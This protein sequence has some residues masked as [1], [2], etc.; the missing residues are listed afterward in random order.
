MTL[1]ARVALA[2]RN[3]TAAQACASRLRD[4]G[5]QVIHT[6]PRGVDFEGPVQ[7]FAP[8]FGAE[9]EVTA[10]GARFV[11]PPRV[12][13]IPEVESVYFPEPPTFFGQ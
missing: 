3:E 7:L 2:V 11:T 10:S 5:F 13:G 9:V 8:A 4:Q 1:H 6:S 12:E